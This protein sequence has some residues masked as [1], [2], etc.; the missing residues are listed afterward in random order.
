[1]PRSSLWRM[2]IRRHYFTALAAE[3]EPTE[4]GSIFLEEAHCALARAAAAELALS[5][6]GGSQT[7]HARSAGQSDDRELLA[8]PSHEEQEDTELKR[9]GRCV[10]NQNHPTQGSFA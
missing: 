2:P 3:F 4:A 9:E 7:R 6:L 8:G 5:E 10:R 1:M